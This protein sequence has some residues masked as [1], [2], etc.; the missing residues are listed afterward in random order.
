MN[1]N[2]LDTWEVPSYLWEVAFAPQGPGVA[3]QR[4]FLVRAKDLA[5]A[6]NTVQKVYID[7]YGEGSAYIASARIVSPSRYSLGD[8]PL[9]GEMRGAQ[10][11][12][13]LIGYSSDKPT[14]NGWYHVIFEPSDMPRLVYLRVGEYGLT[15]GYDM[16]DDPELISEENQ[17][18]FKKAAHGRN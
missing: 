11:A 8:V 7:H 2:D 9:E 10:K 3:V 14:E 1:A 13:R 5:D 17:A 12:L 6:V 16:E 18:L 15:W 4:K